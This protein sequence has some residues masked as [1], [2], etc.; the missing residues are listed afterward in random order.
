MTEGGPRLV[1]A[2]R[3]HL[4]VRKCRADFPT[5]WLLAKNGRINLQYA[6]PAALGIWDHIVMNSD[7]RGRII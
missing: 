3:T 5:F 4:A 1:D 6:A 2:I 7:A